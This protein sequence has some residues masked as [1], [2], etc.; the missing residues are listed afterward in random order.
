MAVVLFAE[1]LKCQSTVCVVHLVG[2]KFGDLGANTGW[3]T[4]G[5]ANQLSIVR[6]TVDY[7]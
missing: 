2:I 7:K 1:K 4:Y 6:Y 3:L 5:L